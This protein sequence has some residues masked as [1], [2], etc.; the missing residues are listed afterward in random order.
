MTIADV[1]KKLAE[2]RHA[3]D[4]LKKV[5]KQLDVQEAELMKKRFELKYQTQKEGGEMNE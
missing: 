1:E 3:Q 4:T 5:R 2:V